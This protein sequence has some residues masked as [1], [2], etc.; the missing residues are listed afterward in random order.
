MPAPGSRVRLGFALLLLLLPL[1][2]VVDCLA[3]AL[4]L[5]AALIF[6]A[7]VAALFPRTRR[8]GLGSGRLLLLPRDRA[9]LRLALPRLLA[10]PDLFDA[11]RIERPARI[12]LHLLP[13][14][15]K[16]GRSRSRSL[17]HYN[18]PPRC[19]VRRTRRTC[20]A[21]HVACDAAP[22]RCYRR[23]RTSDSNRGRLALGKG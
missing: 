17:A 20:P 2:L 6:N 3:P 22:R 1:M 11:L 18:R 19:R 15:L 7:P 23:G 12:A 9:I 8:S 10:F 21:L 14:L 4:G 13:A 16:R 5:L